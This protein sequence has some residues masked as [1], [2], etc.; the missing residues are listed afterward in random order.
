MTAA[1][2]DSALTGADEDDTATAARFSVLSGTR[3]HKARA[4]LLPR[5]NSSLEIL[6]AQKMVAATNTPDRERFGAASLQLIFR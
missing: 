5:C 3:L 1:D 4:G 6:R 2:D